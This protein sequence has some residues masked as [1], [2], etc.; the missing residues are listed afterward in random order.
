MHGGRLGALQG[1]VLSLF[2]IRR[3]DV[4][5]RFLVLIDLGQAV[6]MAAA[7]ANDR[8]LGAATGL[9]N[10]RHGRLRHEGRKEKV[11]FGGQKEK[12]G[13]GLG[14]ARQRVVAGAGAGHVEEMV[15][16]AGFGAFLRHGANSGMGVEFV[17]ER[18]Q[19]VTFGV[20]PGAAETFFDPG[21]RQGADVGQPVGFGESVQRLLV[22][23]VSAVLPG[24][25]CLLY[26]SRCV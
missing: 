21:V 13:L 3:K 6:V 9:A 17:A 24:G 26:T 5:Y 25:V 2:S 11:G 12:F 20:G 16:I 7:A 1:P 8:Q 10:L 15:G 19:R 22:E 4:L 18:A 23:R 14:N